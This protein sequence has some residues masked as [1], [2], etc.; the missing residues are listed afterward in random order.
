MDLFYRIDCLT[1]S[2]P[3]NA[4]AICALLTHAPPARSCKSILN[5]LPLP[6]FFSLYQSSVKV[7]SIAMVRGRVRLVTKFKNKKT[8]FEVR[9]RK[10]GSACNNVAVHDILACVILS[11]SDDC[12]FYQLSVAFIILYC[13]PSQLF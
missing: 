4:V 6:K 1:E 9:G 12:S 10:V 3:P 2:L 7:V 8:Q 11:L 5:P 13:F